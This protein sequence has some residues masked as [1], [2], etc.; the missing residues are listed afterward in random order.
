MEQRWKRA[1]HGRRRL[2]RGFFI[3]A[4]AVLALAAPAAL[5][6]RPAWAWDPVAPAPPGDFTAFHRRFSS[7]LYPYPRHG[8]APLGL[9]GFEVYADATYDSSF[10]S[11]PFFKTVVDGNLPGGVLSVGRV[12]VRKGLPGGVDLGVSYGEALG[13]QVKLV[14]AEVQY[15]LIKG[16]LLAPALSL[17][18]TGTRTVGS[19]A[20]DLHQFGAELLLSKGFAVLTPYIG[21]GLTYS[22]GRLGRGLAERTDNTTRAVA[23]AGLRL[24]LLLPKIIVEV[25]KGEVVQGAVRIGFGL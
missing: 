8:A 22:Q 11:Q 1:Q 19:G 15:A 6:P 12:G 5:A 2:A 4:A 17:R 10:D 20:Y 25:E 21:A 24:N 9:L 18:A 7:D 3:V 16:G 14:S 23:Y 13:S